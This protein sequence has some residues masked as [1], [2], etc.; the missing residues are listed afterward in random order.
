MI[1]KISGAFLELGQLLV[2]GSIIPDMISQI[3]GAFG[4]MGQNVAASGTQLV[5]GLTTGLTGGIPALT[6]ALATAGAPG[7]IAGGFGGHITI[8]NYWDSSIS[9]K[10][11]VELR[12]MMRNT[13][14]GALG[15]ISRG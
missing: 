15:E 14:Y 7:A 13:V 9:S 5:Q 3:E 8:Q 10:D 4:Q 11:R 12:E 2:G 1:D 6:G